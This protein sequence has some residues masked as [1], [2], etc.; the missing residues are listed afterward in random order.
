MA[1]PRTRRR[2]SRNPPRSVVGPGVRSGAARAVRA[3]SVLPLG[4]ALTALACTYSFSG[5]SVPDHIKNVAIPTFKNE[6]LE[7]VLD[8]L[9]TQATITVFQADGRLTI[10]GTGNADAVVE[11]TATVY[12]NNVYGVTEGSVAEEYRV[13]IA[14]KVT[15]KDRVKGRD[16][17]S[18]ESM[19]AAT[20]YRLGDTSGQPANEIMARDESIA[21][22]A[23]DILQNTLED[24]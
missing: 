15:V 20:T 16:L 2:L 5:S 3:L 24:W 18:K 22:L 12:E 8:Q 23:Q 10:G 13:V 19:I 11:G 4:L 14:I 17:W 1:S 21:K 7:P 9:L 6:T